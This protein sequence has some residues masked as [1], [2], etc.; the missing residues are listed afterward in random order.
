MNQRNERTNQITTQ[1][2]NTRAYSTQPNYKLQV[3]YKLLI[4]VEMLC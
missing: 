4:L 2:T 3:L 1:Q